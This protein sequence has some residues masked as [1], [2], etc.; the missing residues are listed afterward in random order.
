[1]G[2]VINHIRKSN[3]FYQGG[4][5][6]VK[7]DC[8]LPANVISSA[9]GVLTLKIDNDEVGSTFFNTHDKN[10]L[11]VIEYMNCHQCK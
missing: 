9:N 2:E 6:W 1:M 5:V 4:W 3:V 11:N 8:F 7:K 10:I